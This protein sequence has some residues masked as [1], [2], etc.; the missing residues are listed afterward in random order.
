[1]VYM[2][3]CRSEQHDAP[4]IDIGAPFPI[5]QRHGR[6]WL[7]RAA[8]EERDKALNQIKALYPKLHAEIAQVRQALRDFPQLGYCTSPGILRPD[9]LAL[10]VPMAR[11]VNAEIVVFNCT[12]ALRGRPVPPLRAGACRAAGDVG[13]RVEADVFGASAD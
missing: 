10:A 1:M 12:V 7:A 6:A 11:P 9:R 5:W 13:A 4:P 2:E 3:T 8:P